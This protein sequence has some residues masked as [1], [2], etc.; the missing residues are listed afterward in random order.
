MRLYIVKAG[1]TLSSIAEKYGLELAQLLA[2]NPQI[3]DPDNIMPGMKIKIAVGPVPIAPGQ[4]EGGHPIN[5]AGQVTE[6]PFMQFPV[7][8]VE[9]GAGAATGGQAGQTNGASGSTG[10]SSDQTMPTGAGL[11]GYQLNGWGNMTGS[12]GVPGTGGA[13]GMG[14]VTGTVGTGGMPGTGG[15]TGMGDVT[16][17]VGTG[18]MAGTG[19]ATGMGDITGTSGMG[20]MT[21]NPG[22]GADDTQPYLSTIP[23]HFAGNPLYSGVGAY[24]DVSNAQAT[25]NYPAANVLSPLSSVSPLGENIQGA[26]YSEAVNVPSPL[27]SVS[28]ASNHAWGTATEGTGNVAANIQTPPMSGQLYPSAQQGISSPWPEAYTWSTPFE[29]MAS[30]ANISPYTLPNPLP[31]YPPNLPANALPN[32]LPV[33]KPCGCGGRAQVGYYSLAEK[34][35]AE[36]ASNPAATSIDSDAGLTKEEEARV[37]A[38]E[39]SIESLESKAGSDQSDQSTASDGTISSASVKRE[40]SGKRSRS[41]NRK[42]TGGQKKS[43]PKVHLHGVNR[44]LRYESGTSKPKPWLSV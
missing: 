17:T 35:R 22:S 5:P 32:Q 28:P 10:A 23:H 14:D 33:K 2:L 29:Y 40:T 31:N 25:T 4:P 21:G 30:N 12:S 7:P 20:G 38:L 3:T 42:R 34:R 43:N 44:T 1:D 27:S 41:R 37:S 13:T 8:A 11:N 24:G 15:A 26:L 9:A 16:G 36:E 19:G 39:Q 18:G 6:T